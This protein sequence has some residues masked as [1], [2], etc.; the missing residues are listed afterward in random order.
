MILCRTRW[1]SGASCLRRW[2]GRRYGDGFTVHFSSR[3]TCLE[4]PMESQPALQASSFTPRHLPWIHPSYR[5]PRAVFAETNLFLTSATYEIMVTDGPG[6]SRHVHATSNVSTVYK[7]YRR[8]HHKD[9]A[10]R[11]DSLDYT[12]I[13]RGSV[14]RVLGTTAYK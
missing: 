14:T 3:R 4:P 11:A 12:H 9:R 8:G 10:C 7:F 2:P 5:R 13:S 1:S 6:R